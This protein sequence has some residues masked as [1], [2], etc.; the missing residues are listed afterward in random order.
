MKLPTVILPALVALLPMAAHAAEL[1]VPHLHRA[2]RHRIHVE[3]AARAHFGYYF[4]RWGWRS[5]GAAGTWYDSAFA[6]SGEP[7]WSQSPAAFA[8]G[9]PSA[10]AIVCTP[11]RPDVCLAEPVI[12]PL[13]IARVRA[14]PRRWR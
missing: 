8:S 1:P 10:P 2:V 9:P 13:A 5:G 7:D 6:S 4:G 14:G 11:R 3:R 12:E